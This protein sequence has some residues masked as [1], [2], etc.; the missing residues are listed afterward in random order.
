MNYIVE[1]YN[2]IMSGEIRTNKWVKKEYEKYIAIV[3]GA[4]DEYWLVEKYAN[5]IIQFCETY[6]YQ[7]KDKFVG[8]P[9]KL[10]LWE[11]AMLSIIYGI[12]HRIT[13]Q[14]MITD[15]VLEIAKKNGKSSLL[16]C[17]IL[18]ELLRKGQEIYSASS[19]KDMAS[20]IF[21]ECANMLEQSPDLQKR[22]KKRQFDIVNTVEGNF[23]K[24]RP[25]PN[26]PD[27]LDGKFPTV[28]VLDEFWLLDVPLYTILKNGQLL[29][30][31]PLFIMIGTAGNKRE[32]LF[33]EQVAYAKQLISGVLENKH[34][35]SLLYELD[36]PDEINDPQNWIKAN[37]SMEELISLE[38]LQLAYEK[39]K[40]TPKTLNEW[41]TKHL[42]IIGKATIDNYYDWDKFHNL[43]EFD[44]K[45]FKGKY[46]LAGFDL[47]RTNDLTAFN[48]TWYN[49]KDDKYYVK[50]QYWCTEEFYEK[51]L[52]DGRLN[53]S[54]RYWYDNGYLKIAGKNLIDYK[55]IVKYANDL[56]KKG[57]ILR[58]IGYDSYSA[59]YLVQEMDAEGFKVGD[60]L[61]AVIQGFKTLSVPFQNLSSLLNARKIVYSN[62]MDEWCISNVSVEKDRNGNYL[63]SKKSN[64]KKIDGFACLLNAFVELTRHDDIFKY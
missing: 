12:R 28:V 13:N 56:V 35:L 22:L 39:A 23:S 3:D 61:E 58:Y 43:Q 30:D 31:E 7:S 18:Y 64:I 63:P 50:T 14:R 29:V 4:D 42:N 20:M 9:I 57:V 24:F 40:N 54:F 19:T 15:V 25:L 49:A 59:P 62:P 6:C 1:Y 46:A 33:D 34:Q 48:T 16:S 44:I 38:K 17:I 8:T 47:S 11:K 21:N 2:A 45:Q 36:N 27:V 41:K 5:H 10:L 55:E 51:M 53:S 32:G 60:C 37:P 52:D 26:T